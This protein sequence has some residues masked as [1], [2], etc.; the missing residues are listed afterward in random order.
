MIMI[1]HNSFLRLLFHAICLSLYFLYVY[2]LILV[3]SKCWI[4]FVFLFR[5]Y[6]NLLAYSLYWCY[7]LSASLISFIN[8]LLFLNMWYLYIW[9]WYTVFWIAVIHYLTLFSVLSDLVSYLN[10]PLEL[11]TN[12]LRLPHRSNCLPICH[13]VNHTLLICVS[14]HSNFSY[15]L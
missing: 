10:R 12:V 7:I 3:H 5:C 14:R 8:L 15:S 11:N 6:F 4:P 2:F 9:S 13:G 1:I